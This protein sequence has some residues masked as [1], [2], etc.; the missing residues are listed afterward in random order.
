MIGPGG[1]ALMAIVKWVRATASRC[2]GCG[3]TRHVFDERVR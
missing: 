3:A 2:G 1:I